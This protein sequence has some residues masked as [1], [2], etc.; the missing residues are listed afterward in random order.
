MQLYYVYINN[1]DFRL[2]EIYSIK[3]L[4]PAEFV[5]FDSQLHLEKLLTLK[6][7]LKVRLGPSQRTLLFFQSA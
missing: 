6:I 1:S 2:P 4:A 7:N 5:T 3:S